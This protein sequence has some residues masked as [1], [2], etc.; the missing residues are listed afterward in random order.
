MKPFFSAFI[1]TASFA[2]FA[3]SAPVYEW[4]G[5]PGAET[6]FSSSSDA[7][8]RYLPEHGGAVS[9]KSIRQD[10]G[11]IPVPGPNLNFGKAESFER[12]FRITTRYRVFGTPD[13]AQFRIRGKNGRWLEGDRKISENIYLLAFRE[14]GETGKW[15]T[16]SRTFFLPPGQASGKMMIFLSSAKDG[17]LQIQSLD[18]T[19]TGTDRTRF[20]SNSPGHIIPA[21]SGEVTVRFPD[22]EHLVKATLSAE[23]EEG[24]PVF[25]ETVPPGA[26][27]GVFRLNRRGFYTL[28]TEVVRRNG[29]RIVDTATAAV[30]GPALPEEIRRQSRYG[31]CLVNATP[32][33]GKELGFSMHYNSWGLR[34]IRRKPD[35]SL[36]YQRDPG[37]PVNSRAMARHAALFGF[38]K[39]LSGGK[40]DGGLYP[41]DDWNTLAEA[42][43]LYV[44]N[45]PDLPDVVNIFNEPNVRW[46][47]TPAELVKLHDVIAGAVKEVRPDLKVGGPAFSGIRDDFKKWVEAGILKN[48]DY[49]IMHAYVNATPPEEEFIRRIIGMQEYLKTTPYADLP[50]AFTEFG[51]C[52]EPGDWKKPVSELVKA[53][54]LA[55]SMILCTVRNIHQLMWFA[56]KYYPRRDQY[57]YS[58]VKPDL[59]PL[60]AMASYQTLIRE[61]AAVKGGGRWIRLAPGVHLCTFRRGTETVAAVWSTDG[62][63]RFEPG[64]LRPLYI[65]TMTGGPLPADQAVTLSPSPVY[66]AFPGTA[67]ADATETAVR[68]ILPESSF[69]L[70]GERVLLPPYLVQSADG[71]FVFRKGAPFGEYAVPVC[72]GGAWTI[73]RYELTDPIRS[74]LTDVRCSRSDSSAEL[75]FSLTTRLP[76]AVPANVKL[77]LSDGQVLSAETVLQSGRDTEVRF[78]VPNVRNGFRHQ[79]TLNVSFEKPIRWDYSAEVDFTPLKIPFFKTAPGSEIWNT[80][81][82]IPVHRWGRNEIEAD[83]RSSAKAFFKAYAEEKGFHLQVIVDDPHLVR[84]KAWDKL[85]NDDSIQAAFDI[86]A[87]K[88]WDPNNFFNC[89]NGHRIVEFGAA[90]DHGKMRP[91]MLYFLRHAEG[92]PKMP[93]EVRRVSSVIRN[94]ERKQTVYNLFFE[95]KYLG[96][97][98]SPAPGERI[99]FALLI[100]DR[101]PG[102]KRKVLNYFNG[103]F[104]KDPAHY[105][106][107][108]LVG[109]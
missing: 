106:K 52:S 82:A 105:G 92:L 50:I 28:K 96:C 13:F 76:E 100:N 78:H 91:A 54:Y 35:G 98:E 53:R 31:I 87:D 80:L 20:I 42:V 109:Q 29:T 6:V 56:A 32:E 2:V 64:A 62:R 102:E 34:E 99:G 66:A 94:E 74:V 33:W 71:T 7:A 44:R 83:A 73:H 25:S 47:G 60:P 3:A 63:P 46:K 75:L 61:L 107:F 11:L 84:E 24:R 1:C 81:E 5:K 10:G 16:S 58:I 51:W 15:V 93:F 43:R 40:P 90:F 95:W 22:P 9:M 77:T 48:M 23:D 108:L 79:G 65:R 89:L 41:P 30:V 38:P 59:T 57:A 26:A 67:F 27:T 19:E 103:I 97:K 49:I 45:A 21:E 12:S 85:W 8:I 69:R 18:I 88:E 68:K 101:N 86:D 55:R 37:R 70:N 104:T 4:S 72:R 17:E 14:G 36:C 39:F